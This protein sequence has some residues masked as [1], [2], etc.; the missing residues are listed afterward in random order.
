MAGQA[1]I[2]R[3]AAFFDAA[4]GRTFRNAKLAAFGSTRRANLAVEND[5]QVKQLLA[6]GTP[7]V[8]IF[9]KSWRLHVTDVLGITPEENRAMIADTVRHLKAHGREVI[10]DA[11]HFFDGYKDDPAHALATLAVASSGGADLLVLCDTNGGCLPEEVEAIFLAA[12]ESLPSKRF[13]I[14]THND[15]GLGVANAL[16]AIRAG[17]VQVQGTINGYGERT[18]IAT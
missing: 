16:S 8:T 1:P 12:A 13:G 17:A 14:H 5:P 15:C 6:S 2:L 10:Y 7:V 3:D 18:E 9:G 11:E 4:K